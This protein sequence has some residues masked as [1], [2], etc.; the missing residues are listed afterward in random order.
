MT[1]PLERHGAEVEALV[2]V[3]AAERAVRDEFGVDIEEVQPVAGEEVFV[4]DAPGPATTWGAV[5]L[6]PL[7]AGEVLDPPPALLRRADDVRLVYGGKLTALNGEPES[8][9]GWAALHVSS[10]VL[11]E[12]GRVLY[13][14]FETDPATIVAR[15]MALGI[16]ASTILERLCY[17]RPDEPLTDRARADLDPCIAEPPIVAVIDG[18]TE[19]MTLHGL[20]LRDNADYARFLD[21]FPRRLARDGAAVLLLDHVTKDREMRGRF[22]IGAQHKLAGVDAAFSLEV[23]RPFGRGCEGLVRLK[24]TKDRPGH[25]RQHAASGRVA[26]MHLIS[27]EDG[28]V[29]IRLEPPEGAEGEFRPT[30]L[31]ER[32]SRLLE[33]GGEMNKRQIRAGALGKQAAKDLALERLIAEGYVELREDGQAHQHR[34]VKPY[35]A[36]Q[37]RGAE[38]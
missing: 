35:R 31:M 28:S 26:D 10:Q 12:G 30:T 2:A 9:K 13:I 18:V 20:D 34:S 32:I 33:N 14:D 7:L 38:S 3:A 1:S 36:D 8:C 27:T 29:E 24:V 16:P 37:E 5:D 6:S 25:I 11:A 15:L 19:G 17:I 23:V 21:L 22:A 4:L